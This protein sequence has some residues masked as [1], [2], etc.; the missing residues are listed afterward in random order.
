VVVGSTAVWARR[1]SI[2]SMFAS[3]FVG[4]ILGEDMLDVPDDC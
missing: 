2:A 1:S 3:E 4:L